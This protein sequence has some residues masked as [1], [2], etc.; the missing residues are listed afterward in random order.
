VSQPYMH[1]LPYGGKHLTF[2]VGSGRRLADVAPETGV[3]SHV[4]V[5]QKHWKSRLPAPELYKVAVLH[6]LRCSL[7]QQPGW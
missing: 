1:A 6:G 2:S 5:A 7:Q 3:V 4:L